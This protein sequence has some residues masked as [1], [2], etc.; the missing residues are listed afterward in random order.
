MKTTFSYLGNK[1]LQILKY[2]GFIIVYQ[3]G[4]TLIQ[5]ATASG[6]DASFIKLFGWGIAISAVTLAFVIWR[7]RVQLRQH[8]PFHFGQRRFT[9]KSITIL[10]GLM[11][12]MMVVQI[13][14]SSLV[15]A[16][17]IS[18][19]SNQKAIEQSL[20]QMPIIN[21]L[22]IGIIGPL[23]EEVICRG[24]F[25]NYFFKLT[26]GRLT[27]FFG[28]ITCGLAFGY[29]HTLSFDLN[30]LFYSTLG[31]ILSFTY[32]YFKDIRYNTILHMFNNLI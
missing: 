27:Q 30:W 9:K 3:I 24:I 21:Y 19:P 28:I 7:Y 4:S 14:W 32:V 10:I 15:S 25:F 16:K 12:L 26:N 29:L 23:F 5:L 31:A 11:V 22:Y 8:N 13:A 2:I 20:N 6:I 1:S 17:F 18:E